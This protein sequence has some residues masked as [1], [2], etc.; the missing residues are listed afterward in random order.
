MRKWLWRGYSTVP[1]LRRGLAVELLS[2]GWWQS[3]FFQTLDGSRIFV[4]ICLNTVVFFAY[5]WIQSYSFLTCSHTLAFSCN[6]FSHSCILLSFVR[7][8]LY[9]VLICSHTFVFCSHTLVFSFHLF[10]YSGILL[11]FVCIHLYY[12]LISSYTLVFCSHLFSCICILLSF[13]LIHLY[14]VYY[15]FSY[16]CILFSYI[17][18]R[19]YSSF[20]CYHFYA[21]ITHLISTSKIHIVDFR[22][23]SYLSGICFHFVWLSIVYSMIGVFIIHMLSESLI[24]L[25][26]T[27]GAIL[28]S[29]ARWGTRNRWLLG[30]RNKPR[31]SCTFFCCYLFNFF[32]K[33]K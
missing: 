33:K 4:L 16:T 18:I 8:H 9:S 5:V 24:H 31:N 11:S 14:S 30:S 19:S 13:V 22:K 10:S 32:S 15:M 7:M 26:L 23:L 28:I 25:S 2:D 1:F 21:F 27:P 3:Y 29:S 12:V 20:K 6:L 17:C